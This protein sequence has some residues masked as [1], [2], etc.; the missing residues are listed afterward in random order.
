MAIVYPL[1][2]PSGIK[3]AEQAFS[4]APLKRVYEADLSKA[5]AT[6]QF[7]DGKSDRWEGEWITTPL[8]FAQKFQLLAWLASL[9]GSLGT[10]KAYDLDRQEPSTKAGSFPGNGLVMGAGQTGNTL[11]CD[12]FPV[13]STILQAGD[14]FGVGDFMAMLVADALTDG[15]GV[16]TLEFEPAIR[17]AFADNAT[18]LTEGFYF[19]ARMTS[20]TAIKTDNIK[21]DAYRLTFVESVA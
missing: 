21:G 12:G 16:V 17:V 18:V 8:T 20:K 5:I 6:G 15:S 19:K 11:V 4:L 13:N 7:N 14:Y 2:F 3:I 1:T 10:F 9:E